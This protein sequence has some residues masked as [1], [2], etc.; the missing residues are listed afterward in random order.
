MEA[1]QCCPVHMNLAGTHVLCSNKQLKAFQLSRSTLVTLGKNTEDFCWKGRNEL[2]SSSVGHPSSSH[3]VL[4]LDL[5]FNSLTSFPDV[6]HPIFKSLYHL[7]LSHNHIKEVPDSL[8]WSLAHLQSLDMSFNKL[9]VV[10]DFAHVQLPLL[11][12]LDL[13]HNSLREIPCG[14]FQGLFGLETLVLDHNWIGQILPHSFINVSALQVLSLHSNALESLPLSVF[15]EHLSDLDLSDNLLEV[16]PVGVLQSLT[17][18]KSL[19]LSHNKLSELYPSSLQSLTSLLNLD[20]SFNQLEGLP[21][22]LFEAL[23]RL[24]R[25]TLA[26]NKVKAI[27]VDTLKGLK[28]LKDLDLSFNQLT[29]IR[30]ASFTHLHQL[31]CL[32]LKSNLLK[33]LHEHVFAGL[34]WL[35]HLDLSGNSLLLDL[36]SLPEEVFSPLANLRT[37]LMHGN[38]LR[39]HGTYPFTLFT[40]LQSVRH[41]SIDT[42]TESTFSPEFSALPN[43]RRLDL[44]HCKMTSLTEDTFQRFRGSI[45][46]QVR[47]SDCPLRRVGDCAFCGLQRLESLSITDR[48]SPSPVSMPQTLLETGHSALRHL[49]LSGMNLDSR[50]VQTLVDHA[51]KDVGGLEVLDLSHNRLEDLNMT[52]KGGLK[53]LLLAANGFRSVPVNL[54]ELK[55]LRVLDMSDNRL[56]YL[57]PQ[58]RS[59]LDKLAQTSPFSLRLRGNRLQCPDGNCSQVDFWTWLSFTRVRLDDGVTRG[60][61]YLCETGQGKVVSVAEKVKECGRLQWRMWFNNENILALVVG[62]VLAGV[63]VMWRWRRR[64]R[65]DANKPEAV[66]SPGESGASMGAEPGVHSDQEY[67]QI[68]N[69]PQTAPTGQ[70]PLSSHL[71]SS[72]QSQY[73]EGGGGTQASGV[74]S[75]GGRSSM[76]RAGSPPDTPTYKH[77]SMAFP[78]CAQWS[79][80]LSSMAGIGEAGQFGSSVTGLPEGE[81]PTWWKDA[82]SPQHDDPPRC[83]ESMRVFYFVRDYIERNKTQR[84]VPVVSQQSALSPE[85]GMGQEAIPDDVSTKVRHYATQTKHLPRNRSTSAPEIS[86]KG[87]ANWRC[88]SH[89]QSGP[90]ADIGLRQTGI[91]GVAAG[92]SPRLPHPQNCTE[93]DVR[94]TPYQSDPPPYESTEAYKARKL[95][96]DQEDL[97]QP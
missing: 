67:D 8:L 15:D 90:H 9:S 23:D 33:R 58:E 21:P 46:E 72:L 48:S 28:S 73:G 34:K 56:S 61:D 35:E 24:E 2:E 20:L 68:T 50:A 22:S 75:T 89:G 52:L 30:K 39:T 60:G 1:A 7:N 6:S 83:E 77:T 12:L 44:P 38:D 17:Q 29:T 91:G 88:F 74:T 18:L 43:L 66:P 80:P 94:G 63:G 25:L 3:Q 97:R 26:K 96:Q 82:V 57:T 14:R 93:T 81:E 62:A 53:E 41:L 70:T 92:H 85:E 16:L 19:N 13:S 5:S 27:S 32:N 36:Q 59:A 65:G 78:V 47:M 64:G 40:H 54:T 45:L 51:L 69:R 76:A 71:S 11:K 10:P 37:L 31:L 4:R 95:Q 87:L 49:N 86:S 42:F 55:R 79:H 84:K